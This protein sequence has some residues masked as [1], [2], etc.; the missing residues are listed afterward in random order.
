MKS[1]FLSLLNRDHGRKFTDAHRNPR[2]EQI[3]HPLDRVTEMTLR[4]RDW[5]PNYTGP[6]EDLERVIL[7]LDGDGLPDIGLQATV[8]PK[9]QCF[10]IP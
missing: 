5:D 2:G 1:V 6:G 8:T 10:N 4:F 3:D 9:E 7:L